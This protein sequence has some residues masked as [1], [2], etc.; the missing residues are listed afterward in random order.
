MVRSRL[1]IVALLL[2]ACE[3]SSTPPG[4]LGTV[5]LRAEHAPA[6]P[7]A[8]AETKR[9]TLK[10]CA[11]EDFTPAVVD[12]SWQQIVANNSGWLLDA[13][14]TLVSAGDGLAVS[15]ESGPSP[16]AILEA[17]DR[18]NGTGLIFIRCAR[19]T[20]RGLR[21]FDLDTVNTI[22]LTALSPSPTLR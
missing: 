18:W 15:L 22:E 3:Q 4:P 16:G 11:H 19:R 5:S 1:V 14:V 8:E 17:A 6:L 2:S 12:I 20:S 10:V 21:T 7:S 9:A 13:S